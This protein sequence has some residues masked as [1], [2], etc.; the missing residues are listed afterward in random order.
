MVF[1][2]LGIMFGAV[3]GLCGNLVITYFY[4]TYKN[5]PW[6]PLIAGISLGCLIGFLALAIYD[7]R[8]LTKA[9]K[10]SNE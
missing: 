4:D 8:K 5:E 1:L 6:M 2:T 7:I 3:L 9:V 10:N